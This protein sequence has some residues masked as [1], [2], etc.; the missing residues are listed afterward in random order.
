VMAASRARVG[1]RGAPGRAAGRDYGRGT[2]AARD[3]SAWRRS[4]TCGKR[5]AA[6]RGECTRQAECNDTA[7]GRRTAA[8]RPSKAITPWRSRSG[9][10]KL[11][12]ATVPSSDSAY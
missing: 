12:H 7:R 3:E 5:T 10:N 11:R 4:V 6:M 9:V 2:T 1:S 8:L